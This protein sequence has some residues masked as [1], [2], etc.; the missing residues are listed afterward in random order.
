MSILD[1]KARRK[2]N[3]TH[4]LVLKRINERNGRMRGKDHPVNISSGAPQDISVA[5]GKAIEEVYDGYNGLGIAGIKVVLL[6][7]LANIAE[8]G[9]ADVLQREQEARAMKRALK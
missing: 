7:H 3:K 9:Y 6:E 2:T 5:I 4:R 1:K 8:L